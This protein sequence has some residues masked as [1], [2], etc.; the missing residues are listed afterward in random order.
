MRLKI[1]AFQLYYLAYCINLYDTCLY[2]LV[3]V[4]VWDLVLMNIWLI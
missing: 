1:A 2:I 4:W 3:G